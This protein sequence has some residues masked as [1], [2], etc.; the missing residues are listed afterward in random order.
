MLGGERKTPQ[1]TGWGRVGPARLPHSF[2]VPGVGERRKPSLAASWPAGGNTR[3]R[4]AHCR[5]IS[6]KQVKVGRGTE[7]NILTRA[8][9]GCGNSQKGR[10]VSH[11]VSSGERIKLQEICPT[12]VCGD[13]TDQLPGE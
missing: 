1:R 5:R 12:K 2:L 11:P 3:K 13:S 7:G 10:S 9:V 6:R 8:C 4:G